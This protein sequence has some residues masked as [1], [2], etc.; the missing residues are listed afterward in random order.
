MNLLIDNLDPN[1]I[2]VLRGVEWNLEH[3]AYIRELELEATERGE[4]TPYDDLP[5]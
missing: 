5:F 3:A 2:H 1:S 4:I